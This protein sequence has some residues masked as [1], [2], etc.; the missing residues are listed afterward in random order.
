VIK[1]KARSRSLRLQ[2]ESRDGKRAF[3]PCHYPPGLDDPF[4]WDQF[5]VPADDMPF[6]ERNRAANFTIDLGRS[7]RELGELLTV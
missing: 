3:G 7:A 5:N 6:E 2:L 4:I 1:H